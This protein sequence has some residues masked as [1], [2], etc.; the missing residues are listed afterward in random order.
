MSGRR[1]R[2]P[3]DVPYAAR[4]YQRG[5]ALWEIGLELGV[6]ETTIRNRLVEIGVT[7]RPSAVR[8]FIDL[9]VDEVVRLYRAGLSTRQVAKRIGVSQSKVNLTLTEAGEP[10]RRDGGWERS[11]KPRRYPGKAAAYARRAARST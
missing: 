8:P 2:I 4:A 3:L 7:I 9:D 10:R 1:P 11:A 6:S 5:A